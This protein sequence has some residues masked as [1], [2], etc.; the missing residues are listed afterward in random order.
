MLKM[1]APSFPACGKVRT[2][3]PARVMKSLKSPPSSPFWLWGWLRA[4]LTAPCPAGKQAACVPWGLLCFTCSLS[5][6]QQNVKVK[7]KAIVKMAW[8]GVQKQHLR[9]G[10][11]SFVSSA[12]KADGTL[13]QL[14][15]VEMTPENLTLGVTMSSKMHFLHTEVST[16]WFAQLAEDT[17]CNT[18]RAVCGLHLSKQTWD[19]HG[20]NQSSLS[21]WKSYLTLCLCKGNYFG[22][23]EGWQRP[24][25][26]WKAS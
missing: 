2:A 26:K 12:W 19:S 23:P 20:E 5:C 13:A 4:P 24:L 6:C 3:W 21:E 17:N 25:K 7:H 10:Y 18:A 8:A 1:W 11:S 9:Y 14:S 22:S 15:W 16:K